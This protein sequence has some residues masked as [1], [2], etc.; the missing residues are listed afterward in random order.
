MKTAQD[1]KNEENHKDGERTSRTTWHKKEG[2]DYYIHD[3]QEKLWNHK[4]HNHESYKNDVKAR[5]TGD[6]CRGNS[7]QF[8]SRSSRNFKI[9]RVNQARFSAI[10]RRD[11]AGVSNML[12]T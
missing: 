10:C 4:D 2:T 8:L 3:N 7:M 6:F 1:H 9:A 12:E 11:I 5:F